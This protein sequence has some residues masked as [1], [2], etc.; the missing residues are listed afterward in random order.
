MNGDT[1]T[2]VAYLRCEANMAADRA[3][4]LRDMAD[5]LEAGINSLENK[6]DVPPIPLENEVVEYAPLDE[7]GVPKYKGRKR[8]RKP[9]RRKRQ[10]NPNSS[11]R[12]HTAYTLFVQTTYPNIKAQNPHLQSKDVISIV[13][14]QWSNVLEEDKKV[15]HERA[16]S[17]SLEENNHV[18]SGGVVEGNNEGI[19]LKEDEEGSDD[20]DDEDDATDDDSTDMSHLK[21]KKRIKD[22]VHVDSGM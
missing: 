9:K 3:K 4:Q 2:F 11:K 1:S 13:A 12:Q 16:K 6:S 17:Y 7:N 14:K 21:D 22:I 8:G 15:W 5:N 20:D 18:V 19:S 10:R